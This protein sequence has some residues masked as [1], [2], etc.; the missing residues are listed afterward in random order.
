[1][2][3]RIGGIPPIPYIDHRGPLPFMVDGFSAWVS[4]EVTVNDETG[5]PESQG[6]MLWVQ[7]DMN[8]TVAVPVAALRTL[9]LATDLARAV[10][11]DDE[12]V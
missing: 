8:G 6:P 2:I 9:G 3:P 10:L 12:A 1:V 4:L 7:D 5:E 11:S